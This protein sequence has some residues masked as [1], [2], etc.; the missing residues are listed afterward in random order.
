MCLRAFPRKPKEVSVALRDHNHAMLWKV[1][2]CS[3]VIM[4]MR[5]LDGLPADLQTVL[6]RQEKTAVTLT[7]AEEEPEHADRV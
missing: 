3:V 7:Q 5:V 4:P 2:A 6:A 1:D